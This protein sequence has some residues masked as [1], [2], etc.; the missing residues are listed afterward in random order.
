MALGN[1]ISALSEST[2][3]GHIP[4]RQSKIT[5]ILQDSLGGNSKTLM[6]ACISPSIM[7]FEET[8]NTLKYANRAKNIRNKAIV[9]QYPEESTNNNAVVQMQN[10]IDLLKMKLQSSKHPNPVEIPGENLNVISDD[11]MEVSK[12]KDALLAKTT[13]LDTVMDIIDDIKRVAVLALDKNE[14]AAGDNTL[15][16]EIR[17]I[18][19][20]TISDLHL[21]KDSCC[22]NNTT[23]VKRRRSMAEGTAVV[24][25]ELSS[26]RE[27][28]T[29]AQDD[30]AKDEEIFASKN[31]EIIKLQNLLIDAKAKNEVLLQRLEEMD[32]ASPPPLPT[33]QGKGAK[34]P[35]QIYDN[36]FSSS[37][38]FSDDNDD[39]VLIH[40]TQKE[41]IV[42]QNNAS[43]VRAKNILK[44]C[45]DIQNLNFRFP[46]SLMDTRVM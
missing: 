4:Y 36:A 33:P 43:N 12:L 41:R 23:I 27:Q 25:K 5:R 19:L 24:S 15:A 32:L 10:E 35:L 2:K 7:S 42:E 46:I 40:S 38:S 18:F 20:D 22:V 13:K 1:V 3:R 44:R 34:Y 9:N 45:F 39:E 8:V 29:E 31:S 37:T 14:Y 26:L 16:C 11:A 28:L 6:I 17:N 21:I 30:L